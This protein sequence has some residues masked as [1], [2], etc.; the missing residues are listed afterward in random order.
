MKIVIASS[1]GYKIRETKTFLKQL[2]SFDI[3][4]LADFPDYYA[5]KE[6]G[7]LPEDNALAKGLHAAKEL[8]SWVI[9]DDTMLMVPALNGLPGKFSATFAG[10]DAC[11]KDH[12]KKL[13]QEMQSLESIVDRSA[14][15]ECCVVLAS[16]EGKFFKSRG[17]CEGYI[18]N[19]EKGSSGFGY[20]SLFLKYDYKQTFAELSEDVKNQVSHRAKALQKLT[21]Y[22]Q[23]LLEK[24][25]VSRN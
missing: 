18:S 15:F 9:A 5:P 2:G 25:L 19:H 17:I 4:S 11:D 10:E 24:H 13:L 21:P 8:N 20:D 6:I 16:P 1:H 7:S 12:R 23:D 22:L 14:Y 3:F